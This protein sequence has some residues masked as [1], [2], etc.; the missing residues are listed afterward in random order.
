MGGDKMTDDGYKK[1]ALEVIILAIKDYKKKPRNRGHLKRYFF[2]TEMLN[3]YA[4]I[5]DLDPQSIRDKLKIIS[6]KVG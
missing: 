6:E 4:Y 1:L 3:F 2:D 5:C